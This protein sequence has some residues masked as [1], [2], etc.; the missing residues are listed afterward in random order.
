MP[1]SP[2]T[3]RLARKLHSLESAVYR[4]KEQITKLKN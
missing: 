4:K 3:G 2:E 1:A